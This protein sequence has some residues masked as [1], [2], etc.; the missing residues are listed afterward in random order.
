MNVLIDNAPLNI[1]PLTVEQYHA[2]LDVG[3]LEEGAP[4]ELLDGLMVYKDCRDKSDVPVTTKPHV[5]VFVDD[6]E[7]ALVAL[8]VDQY[9]G[10]IRAGVLPEGAPI[11]LIDGL[12][13]WKDRRGAEGEVMTVDPNHADTLEVVAE[14]LRELLRDVHPRVHVR[15]QQPVTLPP[16]QEP[17]PDIAIVHGPPGTYR[18]RHPSRSEVLLVVEVA[19][20]SLAGDRST[21]QS[22]YAAAGIPNYWIVNLRNKTVEVYG[23]PLP[24]DGCYD[25]FQAFQSSEGLQFELLGHKLWLNVASIFS[26]AEN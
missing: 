15:C 5:N 9:H 19:S 25:A 21:K 8:N 10:M 16:R 6:V 18:Q 23:A 26:T 1:V 4:I 20:S 22:V 2:M 7:L 12:L 3:V 24:A 17:E 11:E 13:V 14:L